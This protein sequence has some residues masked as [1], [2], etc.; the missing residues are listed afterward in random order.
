M[1]ERDF[2]LYTTAELQKRIFDIKNEY[3]VIKSGI[4]KEIEKL[5]ALDAENYACE[6]ELRKRNFV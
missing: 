4:L 1:Q 6:L 2:S 3:E 5:D